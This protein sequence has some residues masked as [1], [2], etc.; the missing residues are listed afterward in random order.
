VTLEPADQRPVLLHLE[1]RAHESGVDEIN[2]QVPTVNTIAMNHL[3]G[4][5]FKIDA[6]LN[7]F[8]SNREFG[9]FD[10]FVAFGP[11]IVL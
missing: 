5:G 6:P 3:L 10:R 11:P 8:M 2:F 1:R 9:L 4:R 7:L